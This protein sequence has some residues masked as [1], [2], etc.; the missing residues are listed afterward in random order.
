MSTSSARS[1]LSFVVLLVLASSV[2]EAVGQ[3]QNRSAQG[4]WVPDILDEQR[5]AVQAHS[6][7][8]RA[9]SYLPDYSYAGYRWGEE[10][11]PAPSGTVIRAT[12][13]GA[14]PNDGN[15]DTDAIQRALREAH[16]TSGPVTV[17]VPSG[18]LIVR[19]VLLL[20]RSDLVLRGAGQ[21][22][23]TLYFPR[24]LTELETPGEYEDPLDRDFS[25]FSWRGGVVWTRN[26]Q[27]DE[28]R[29][30]GQLVA[31]RRGHHT[32]KTQVPLS[33]E[34]GEV[35]QIK[36]ANREGKSS[37]LLHHIYCTGAV[38]FGT[39]LYEGQAP[40]VATQE[41]TVEEVRGRTVRIKEPLLH[42]LRPR[43]GATM[44]TID[45]L[46]KVGIEGMRIAFPENVEYAGHHQEAGYNGLYLTDLKHSWV[47]D[48]AV[49][50]ADSGI[51]T[52]HL[53]N[54][55]IKNVA[56]GR[57]RWGHYSIHLGDVYGVLV[58]DFELGPTLH[59]PS[60]NTRSRGNVYSDGFVQSPVLDQHMGINHQNLF[61]D[62]RSRY[63]EPADRLFLSG[64]SD[65]RWGPVAGAFN[66]FW[67]IQVSIRSAGKSPVRMRPLQAGAPYARLV[68]VRGEN[69][70]IE[71][72]Y[73][74]AP[75]IEGKN[76]DGIA[77][78][79]LYDYQRE[80]RLSG[81]M[82]PSLAIYDPLDGAGFEKGESVSIAAEVRGNFDP[83]R[84]RF[85]ADGTEIGIDTDGDDTWTVT[86]QNPSPGSHSITAL[87]ED[88]EGNTL[89]SRPL[90]CNGQPVRMWVGDKNNLLKGNA[91]NPFRDDTYIE[92]VLPETQYVR[93]GIFDVLGRKVQ[94]LVSEM[95][96]SGR[97][98][99]RF[100]AGGLASGVYYYRLAAGEYTDT[101]KAVVVR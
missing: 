34:E 10:P 30:L 57:G 17:R 7:N 101:G 78:E 15:D 82:S 39:N 3:A 38:E 91:P 8:S 79:S 95:K 67:N 69:V 47:R 75:Y 13:F 19:E 35:V 85:L 42:D 100:D 94:T 27:A 70:P 73:G 23:T 25:P 48:V 76:R 22:E 21:S 83:E 80:R 46:E 96:F 92:Y 29:S 59:N 24:P 89:S 18:R 74:P 54:V 71:F 77:V 6:S 87:A 11:L 64:G 84:V 68:G 66:T 2:G 52:S 32:V 65:S 44:Y 58:T 5:G 26:P 31:G 33:M 72:E 61:D 37:S 63:N 49:E 93:L 50:H 86:W 88:E 81:E 43:W 60:F 55:T 20:E 4:G 9:A 14:V 51:L 45:Y 62:L 36:W 1:L 12:E 56:A 98:R 97:H 28:Q 90:S 41:V 16:R 53:K 40:V 99:E